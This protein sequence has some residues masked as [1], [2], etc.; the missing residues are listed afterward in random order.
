MP[1]FNYKAKAGPGQVKTGVIT[2]DNEAVVA[3]KLRQ[4]GLFPVSIQEVNLQASAMAR[5][6]ANS[7]D[8]T[9]FTRQLANLIHSGF[10]LARALTTLKDQAQQPGLKKLIALLSEKIE[11][12][13]TFSAALAEYP[14]SFSSFYLSMIKIGESSGNLDETLLRL[15]DFKEKEDELVSQVKAALTYPAFLF[16]VGL[17][18]LFVLLTFFVPRLVGIY[19]D[20]GQALPLLTQITIAVSVV[21]SKFWWLIILAVAGLTVFSRYYWK[22]E[23]N[24]LAIDTVALGIP[25]LKNVI[26]QIEISRFAYALAM[27]LKSGVP[28]LESIGVVTLSVD[29]RL[30]RQKIAG[31]KEKISKGQSLSNCFR[32]E[33]I[34]PPVLSNMAAVGEEGG[35]LTEMLFRIAANFEAEVNRTVK[36][37]VSLIEPM[38]IIFIG[39]IVVLLVFAVL[40]PIF[41]LDFFNK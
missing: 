35:E 29:N 12:G 25:V 11:K 3:K 41:Q 24:R 32:A 16:A 20:F 5:K 22:N 4:D 1:Q 6:K 2:A 26:Q 8:I 17:I 28:V 14:E 30:F 19:A 15:A 31:F 38:L 33:K 34:F 18:T 7:R 39:G 21:M 36:T 10:S 23:K 40:L 27:L 37:M 13:S 9:E